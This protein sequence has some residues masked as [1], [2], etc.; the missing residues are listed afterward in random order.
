MRIWMQM[1]HWI[2][3]TLT[4]FVCQ[5][6]VAFIIFKLHH[7]KNHFVG[8]S[9]IIQNEEIDCKVFE[10]L[11]KSWLIQINWN[12]KMNWMWNSICD[13]FY[14]EIPMLNI[15][16]WNFLANCVYFLR[17]MKLIKCS[18]L[19]TTTIIYN[20]IVGIYL[21]PCMNPIQLH[22]LVKMEK[23]IASTQLKVR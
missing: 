2:D 10:T 16:L 18:C 15:L 13:N 3:L 11:E 21:I 23:K 14:S 8:H 9:H 12:M 7:G 6:F 20:L 22:N 19:I 17:I 4:L 1:S 5:L